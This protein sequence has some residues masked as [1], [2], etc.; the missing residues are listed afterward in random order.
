MKIKYNYLFSICLI[1]FITIIPIKSYASEFDAGD[2][3][4]EISTVAKTVQSDTNYT[5]ASN[6]A[7]IHYNYYMASNPALKFSTYYFIYS[8]TPIQITSYA[9][10][11]HEIGYGIN[12]TG[13]YLIKL[14]EYNGDGVNDWNNTS[15]Q[16]T[17]QMATASGGTIVTEYG[18]YNFRGKVTVGTGEIAENDSKI[19]GITPVS[20]EDILNF[21][22]D[23]NGLQIYNLKKDTNVTGYKNTLS[24]LGNMDL[25]YFDIETY[26]KFVYKGSNTFFTTIAYKTMQT[27]IQMATCLNYGNKV[28][29]AGEGIGIKEFK[30]VSDTSHLNT[31]DII[32]FRIVYNVVMSQ[33][34]K[35]NIGLGTTINNGISNEY[36]SDS[37]KDITF[38]NSALTNETDAD[39]GGET[40]NVGNEPGNTPPGGSTTTNGTFSSI[41]TMFSSFNGFIGSLFGFLPTEIKVLFSGVCI[42]IVGL[43]VKRAVL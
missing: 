34:G 35:Y 33:K 12:S 20:Q 41:I 28:V 43:M 23:G 7:M 1:L 24:D 4:A 40:G 15:P 32:K 36:I 21:N 19:T 18:L 29:N 2:K 25:R 26:G 27:S 16:Y 31:G 38:L 9:T 10:A 37:V 8:P 30:W 42:L 39:K 6:I 11:G 13:T 14:Q 3:T 5:N 22:W 17:G